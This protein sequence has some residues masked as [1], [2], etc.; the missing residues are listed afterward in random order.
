MALSGFCRNLTRA[1]V[2]T[3][4]GTTRTVVERK[5]DN[6]TEETRIGAGTINRADDEKHCKQDE[7][8]HVEK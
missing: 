2:I 8:S 4:A 3:A 1:L 6:R 7:K 5:T